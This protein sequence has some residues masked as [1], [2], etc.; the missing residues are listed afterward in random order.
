MA[1]LQVILNS[2]KE[3]GDLQL[4]NLLVDGYF[5]PNT[6]YHLEICMHY[7]LTGRRKRDWR[8]KEEELSFPTT[9]N[10][11]GW[12]EADEE[13]MKEFYGEPGDT[14]NH[15]MIDLP[16]PL[17]IAWNPNQHTQKMTVNKRIAESVYRCLDKT[18]GT[19]GREDVHR[20][21]LDLFGGCYNLRKKR[22]GSTLSTHAFAAALD[23]DPAR[24]GLRMTS[25]QAEFAKAI[26]DPWWKIW[27]GEGW[28]SLGRE[29]NY[30]WMHIQA[31]A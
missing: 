2:V 10:P 29:L 8:K 14:S 25:D 1:A 26:Y 21:G 20:L 18:L 15:M 28:V 6:E 22:G 4:S 19:Y 17:R 24:N 23:F 31:T 27:E 11:H 12:P 7:L 5:G 3:E 16:Y 13:S 30:D 9:A